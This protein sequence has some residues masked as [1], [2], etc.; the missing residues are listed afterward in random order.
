MHMYDKLK[1]VLHHHKVALVKHTCNDRI[2]KCTKAVYLDV[3]NV[4]L[5]GKGY[6]TSV[7]L[8]FEKYM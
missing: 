2:S 5:F 3:H 4:Y 6:A 7:D 1:N 8:K